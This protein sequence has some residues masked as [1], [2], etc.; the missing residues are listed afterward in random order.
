MPNQHSLWQTPVSSRNGGLL[1]LGLFA[2]VAALGF[3]GLTWGLSG[4]WVFF[5]EGNLTLA[6]VALLVLV[7]MGWA[8]P[9]WTLPCV[10]TVKGFDLL[11]N[12]TLWAAGLLPVACAVGV[13]QGFSNSADEYA[14][15]FQA[16]TYGSGHLWNPAPILG[17]ALA[18]DYT[19]VKDGKWAGQYP[20]GWPGMLAVSGW[21]G[22]PYWLVNPLLAVALVAGLRR[23]AGISNT[24]LLVMA[25]SPFFIFNAASYHSHLAAGLLG[26]MA[27]LCLEKALAPRPKWDWALAAGLAVGGV[28]LVR[29]ISAALIAAPFALAVLRQRR[30]GVLAAVA[31]GIAPCLAGVLWYHASITGD[32]LKPVYWM[33]GRTADH[34]YFDQ[35]GMAEGIRISGWRLIELVEW[36][37][38]GLVAVWFGVLISKIRQRKLNA[39][40]W[41]MPL[42]V[43]VFLFYPFDGANRYGP[44]YYFE[45]FPFLILTLRGVELGPMAKRLLCLSL[46]YN[47]VALPFLAGFYRQMVTE[48]MD[49]YAQVQSQGLT[50]AVVLVKDGPG[51]LW[52]MEPD[53]MARNGLTADGPVLYARADKTTEA[54]LHHAFPSRQVWVYECPDRCRLRQD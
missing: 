23:L 31:L 20:P 6:W 5:A 7:T 10:P 29:Y 42:F 1:F 43:L 13:L 52:K 54:E 11:P 28:G 37:G 14:Y 27:V 39:A 49:L 4:L 12:W 22:I 3:A 40:D 25:C 46:V 51:R 45:A 21:C 33:G 9:N 53:D 38:P 18:A 41:V 30:W 47:L 8:F 35:A 26:V 24:V 32:P 36:A 50:N 16:Q 34:L 15:L 19:W 44:R 2:L 48:R 17:Q